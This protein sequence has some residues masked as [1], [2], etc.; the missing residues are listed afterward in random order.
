M[1]GFPPEDQF[2]VIL[3]RNDLQAE[4][5]RIFYDLKDDPGFKYRARL[6][7]CMPAATE[8]LTALQPADFI[9]Y[10]TFRLLHDKRYGGEKI[11]YVLQ[12]MFDTNGFTGYYFGADTFTRMKEPMESAACRPNGFVVNMPSVEEAVRAKRA[13]A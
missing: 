5:V 3:D 1:D 10:E 8:D 11:R 13:G 6:A 7:G 2:T 12:S 4:A 9:A